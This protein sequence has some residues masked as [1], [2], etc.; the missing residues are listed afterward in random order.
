ML[1][2]GGKG[3]RVAYSSYKTYLGD[4]VRFGD[5]CD[6]LLIRG[7]GFGEGWA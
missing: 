4:A 6:V 5:G 2:Y 7:T 3:K 1:T